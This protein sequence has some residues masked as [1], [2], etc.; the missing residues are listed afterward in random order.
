MLAS[1]PAA[2][3]KTLDYPR[4]RLSSIAYFQ[5]P[6]LKPQDHVVL[7][8]PPIQPY[9]FA[10]EEKALNVI[11]NLKAQREAANQNLKAEREAA[12]QRDRELERGRKELQEQQVRQEKEHQAQ[13]AA[14]ELKVHVI[15]VEP[16]LSP[17]Q[18]AIVDKFMAFTGV[19]DRARALE[20][21]QC[22]DWDL[23]ISIQRYFDTGDVQKAIEI[24]KKARTVPE[25]VVVETAKLT[26]SFPDGSSSTA[27]FNPTDTL[28][29]VFYHVHEGQKIQPVGRMITFHTETQ[30]VLTDAQFDQTLKSLGLTGNA[31]LR[32]VLA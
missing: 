15:A 8:S 24:S 26:L 31:S 19:N 22:V 11:R 12:N 4:L 14:A 28:W 29:T 18:S 3:K 20:L 6:S 9:N 5:G 23:N 7:T 27:Q 30:Q 25:P 10:N 1:K 32:I 2:G 16:A 17:A 21:N 13:A